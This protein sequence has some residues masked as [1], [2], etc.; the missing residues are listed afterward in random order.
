MLKA[1]NLR[2]E[3]ATTVA[4]DGVSLEARSGEIL[5]LLGPNGAG[6]TTTIRMILNIIQPDAG[7]ITFDGRPFSEEIRNQFGYLPEE[8]GL[9]RKNKLL[10]TILYFASLKGIDTGEAKRRAYKWLERFDLLNQYQQRIET[11]SKG[12]QQKVQFIISILHDPALLILDEP[13]SGLDPV[14]QILLKDILQELKREGRAIVFSTH[15][16]DQAEKLSDSICL[17]N[18]GAMVLEGGVKEVKQRFGR[19]SIH[20]EY[21]GDGGFLKQL[22]FVREANVYE[23]YA[24]LELGM[25]VPSRDILSAI[26]SKLEIRKFEYVEP[27]LNSIFLNVVGSSRQS[28]NKEQRGAERNHA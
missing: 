22:P 12:N 20:L 21:D 10:N 3:F 27:S 16:M 24:E 2:K 26:S 11:L 5:G 14:N 9:Y 23:N 28:D 13:F 8:R 25:V 7:S 18:H 6:K 17:I 15:Q 4:V 19:N 1:I